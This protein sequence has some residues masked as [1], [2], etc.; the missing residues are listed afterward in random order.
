MRGQKHSVGY[1]ILQVCAGVALAAFLVLSD[2][3]A[4]GLTPRGESSGTVLRKDALAAGIHVVRLEYDHVVLLV[5]R[6]AKEL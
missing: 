5:N 4:S 2:R 1:N 6:L 3:A